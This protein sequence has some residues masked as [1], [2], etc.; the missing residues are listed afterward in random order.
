L[1]ATGTLSAGAFHIGAGAA[2][3]DDR[4][5]YNNVTGA[6]FYDSNGNAAGGSI[7]FADLSAGLSLTFQDFL[8][9]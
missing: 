8:I 9:T 3:A 4:I 7:Q 1:T 2:A 5:I 6:L